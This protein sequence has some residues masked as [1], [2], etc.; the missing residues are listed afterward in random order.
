[1]IV[2]DGHN[3]WCGIVGLVQRL[4]NADLLFLVLLQLLHGTL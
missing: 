2:G 4:C 1:M 3:G